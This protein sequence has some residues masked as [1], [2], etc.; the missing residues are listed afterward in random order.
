[1]PEMPPPPIETV[2][3][4][5]ARLPAPASDAAFSVVT[6]DRAEIASKD[7]L[8]DALRNVPGLS[9]FRRT[10]SAAANP[11]TQGISLRAIAPS[12]AG[13]TLVTLDGVPQNDPFGGW[14]IWTSLPPESIESANVIRGAGAGPYGSGALTGVIALNELSHVPGHV[15]GSVQYGDLDEKRGAVVAD[16][17]LGSVNLFVS[18]SAEHTKGWI[19]IGAGRGA[20]DI[21]LSLSAENVAARAVTP[22]GDAVLA[23]HAGVYRED[24][25]AG[26]V[27]AGSRAQGASGS[28]TLAAQPKSESSGW[29][30]QAWFRDS[31]LRNTSV[32]VAVGRA[33]TTP[34]NEQ[35]AVPAFGWGVNA[36]LR[37]ST[38]DLEWETGADLRT[39]EGESREYFRYI[40]G[41]YTRDR[42]SGG[43]TLVT[44]LYG[45][46]TYSPGPWL[47]TSGVRLDYWQSTNAQRIER[48]LATNAITLNST[49]T[50]E[51]GLVP[52]ARAG[53]R[54]DISDRLYV[55]GAAYQGFRTP[56]LNEL[57]R[58]F[59][60]GNDIT[61]ANPL[62]EPENLFGIEA[63]IGGEGRMTWNATAFFNSLDNAIT[64]VTIG[65]G[66]ATFPIAG[67]IPAGGTLRQRQ[68]AG[69]IDG[70][71]VEAEL[72]TGISDV[73]TARLAAN[74]TY[75][76]VDGGTQAPQLT[77]K[78]PAQ[79]PRFS[80]NAGLD[81]KAADQLTL[82]LDLRYE[83]AR[84]DDDINSRR[85]E[86]ATSVNARADWAL[87]S[88]ISLFVAADNLFDAEV[89]TASN[90]DGTFS[91]AAPRL[92]RIGLNF[93]H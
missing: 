63:A 42:R 64:N 24:R 56:T 39:S 87:N 29:R 48:D 20:A 12:G 74:Y 45:E 59:R 27:G 81:W 83:S 67:L 37:N 23:A 35:Y 52:T 32:A 2:I 93:R 13:R 34:A 6:L 76:R 60:V 65:V 25:S 79:A 33:T 50:D 58:P 47:M 16:A 14:V 44:G 70:T 85:L 46:V 21:P 62:L 89:Q 72:S 80:A 88:D 30:L 31:D 86:A 10:S 77:G 57:H 71:G 8:D 15:A 61:E 1:M 91:Y 84:F 53:V 90:A 11:T 69:R 54:Y 9:L 38:A 26:L 22:I 75:A 68:N 28:L 18:A 36:A 7:R 49:T 41:T 19:P 66:P 17:A 43:N 51:S 40:G 5:V 55:R 3:V 92:W 73:L 78:R 4:Q 82:S